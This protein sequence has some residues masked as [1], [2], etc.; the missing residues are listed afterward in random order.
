[1]KNQYAKMQTPPKIGITLGDPAGIGP[2]IIL[3]AYQKRLPRHISI[4]YGDVLL[5][6]VANALSFPKKIHTIRDVT[7][8]PIES[9]DGINLLPVTAL[10]P[11]SF[12]VGHPNATTGRAAGRYIEKAIHAA[13]HH[14]IDAVVTCPIQKHA[15]HKGGYSYPGHTEMFATLTD[16]QR[17]TMMMLSHPLKV[18]LV[19]LHLPLQNVATALTAA[20]IQEVIELTLTAL[21]RWFGISTP[22]I[23]VLGLNP[24]AGEE[25]DLGWEEDRL[26]RPVIQSFQKRGDTVEGPLPPDTAF[27]KEKLKRYDAYIA[28]YHDQ[29]LIPFKLMAFHT[30]V[31]CTLGLPFPRL[32][33]DH[34][35]GLDIAG[36]GI[37]DPSSLR[38]AIRWAVAFSKGK[39]M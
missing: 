25:G 6:D 34:G 9:R 7:A 23:G 39:R 17:Y 35:T 10:R 3:K 24:H 20:R 19:T 14:E 12:I 33:V 22:R 29:G 38:S 37:A 31:N 30:G 1:M 27:L 4:V 26:I 15:F 21:K 28:M 32:S 18:S 11:S 5:M 8:S 2:E 13:L 36:K 16:A